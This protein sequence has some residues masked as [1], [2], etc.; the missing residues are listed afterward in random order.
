MWYILSMNNKGQNIVEY[1]LLVVAV[2]LVCLVIASQNGGP[3]KTATNTSLSS[4]EI[5]INHLNDEIK[6]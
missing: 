5:Q 3:M 2:V 6:F 4:F 1:I